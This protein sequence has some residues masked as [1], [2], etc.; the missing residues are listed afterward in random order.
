MDTRERHGTIDRVVLEEATDE[1]TDGLTAVDLL[2]RL[3]AEGHP[4]A[5][6]ALAVLWELRSQ[7]L[8]KT[9]ALD[10]RTPSGVRMVV[11]QGL[12]PPTHW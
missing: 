11:L 2:S 12:E 1:Q 7:R 9:W 4:D 3:A 8:T 10:P 6:E 5:R